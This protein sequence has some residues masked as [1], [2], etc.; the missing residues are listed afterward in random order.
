MTSTP[1]AYEPSAHTYFTVTLSS[2]STPAI[3]SSVLASKPDFHLSL[4][5]SIGQGDMA[6][7]MVVVRKGITSSTAA[8]EQKEEIQRLKEW[9]EEL[10]EV[11]GRVEVLQF[12]KRSKR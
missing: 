9:L 10:D 5:G 12:R 2:G 3:L 4:L 11:E 8:D 1:L 7:E 6:S